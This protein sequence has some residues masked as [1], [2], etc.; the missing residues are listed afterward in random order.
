[1]KTGYRSAGRTCLACMTLVAGITSVCACS[2][3]QS[4]T[5]FQPDSNQ[6]QQSSTDVQ[7]GGG[8]SVKP[9]GGD[10]SEFGGDSANGAEREGF[11]SGRNSETSLV[12]GAGSQ[13]F[14]LWSQGKLSVTDSSGANLLFEIDPSKW[15]TRTWANLEVDGEVAASGGLRSEWMAASDLVRAGSLL[16]DEA[17]IERLA[18]SDISSAAMRADDLEAS[19]VRA[20]GIEASS[21]VFERAMAKVAELASLSS[22]YAAFDEAGVGYLAA[23]DAN[24]SSLSAVDAVLKILAAGTASISSLDAGSASVG[25]LGATTMS[26]GSLDSRQ[27]EFG[28]VTTGSM[29]SGTSSFGSVSADTVSTGSLRADSVSGMLDGFRV[30]AGSAGIAAFPPVGSDGTG[31][32]STA[33][34]T[35]GPNVDAVLVTPFAQGDRFQCTYEVEDLGDGKWRIVRRFA[36]SELDKM[37]EGSFAPIGER[38]ACWL[39]IDFG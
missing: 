7:E 25:S 19:A 33:T 36:Q 11:D 14:A 1:M 17:E 22:G 34:I 12:A 9:S 37:A 13:G 38:Y 28:R 26:A 32:L 2:S 31:S 10:R 8:Q 16:S 35:V 3:N 21:S 4:P 18:A 6:A 29:S 30:D 15:R 5:D 39:A 24:V 20:D 27:A 23:G